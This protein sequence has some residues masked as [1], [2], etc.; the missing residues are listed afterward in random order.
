MEP[1]GPKGQG[2]IRVGRIFAGEGGCSQVREDVPR[3]G[4]MFPGQ[5]GCS[6]VEIPNPAPWKAAGRGGRLLLVR[7]VPPLSRML[8]EEDEGPP[9]LLLREGKGM[10]CWGQGGPAAAGDTRSSPCPQARL[11]QRGWSGLPTVPGLPKSCSA[12]G[13]PKKVHLLRYPT[14]DSAMTITN[15]A[16]VFSVLQ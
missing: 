2:V 4:R 11:S 3:S 5:G 9:V 12:S 16:G 14:G 10:Q 13:A 15:S 8:W 1:Q 7:D 6:Q